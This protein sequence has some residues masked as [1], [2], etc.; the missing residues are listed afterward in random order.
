MICRL[1]IC[2]IAA[3]LL[4]PLAALQA[5]AAPTIT[6][7]SLLLEMVDPAAV[8]RWPQ[9][10]FTC[11][12]ASSYDRAKVAPDKPGWFA[13]QDQ[14]QFIRTDQIQ[15]RNEQVLLDTP[16][17][18]CMV[19]FWLTT[20]GNKNGRLRIYLDDAAEPVVVFPAYDL[21]RGVLNIAAPLAQRHPGYRPDGNGGNTLYLPIPYARHCKVTWE[22]AGR[23]A[24]FYQIN[25][26]TYAPGTQVETFNPATVEALR[27]AIDRVNKTLLTPPEAAP[28]HTC[29]M[30]QDLPG[31]GTA[32]LDLPAGPQAVRQLELRVPAESTPGQLRSL[33]VQMNA[34]GEETIWCPVSDFFGSGVGLNPVQSWYRTVRSD[35][36][37]TCR[38]V[39]PYQKEAHITLTNLGTQAVKLALHA[40][41]SPWSWDDR[42]MHFHAV[43][44]H[45]ANLKTPPLRDWNYA[46]V[47]G[48]GVY[49]GDTLALFNPVATWYGEGDEKIW[50][51]GES[52]PSHMG[53]GTEDY[54][55]FSYAPK[56]VH[57]TPFCG[58][59]RTD[60]PSTLGHNTLT[61]TRNL[62]GI[63]FQRS[64]QFDME[65][66]SWAPTTL[67][68]AA[69]TYWYAFAGATSN[70][71]PQPNAAA[72]ALAELPVAPPPGR[73][74]RV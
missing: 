52:F 53:T 54:Y 7:E 70:I 71:K 69:T 55:G 40:S 31:G 33:V 16:G 45:E 25:Y 4:A 5:G 6:L 37:M 17:P 61:R 38:W 43:W 28:L 9:P 27:P 11:R 73:G 13:N 18:G 62:D 64:F 46:A 36:T 19:R 8:A 41:I 51:D 34:D 50:V 42:S 57:H 74:D 59:P 29:R 44:H 21:L 10:E 32:A 67:T 3:L 30:V 23:S 68:Y 58:E 15:G 48:R 26:R 60:H 72:L 56:P 1:T 12:Q 22:E 66:I 39:M 49:V 63:P 14:N 65:L 20:D 47:C 2:A 24:R 35:G